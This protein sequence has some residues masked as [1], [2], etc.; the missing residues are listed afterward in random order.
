MESKLA[1][2]L[3]NRENIQMTIQNSTLQ[4]LDQIERLYT[5]ARDLQ[6]H[7]KMVV[8]PSFSKEMI[9]QEIE[10]KKQFKLMIDGQI[11]CVWAI[12]FSDPQIWKEKNTDAAIYIHRIATNRDFRGKNF[13]QK[14]VNWSQE[15]IRN[16]PINHI[17]LDT[18]GD[19]KGLIQHYTN[20]GFQF[21]GLF[22][23]HE[24]QGL[25]EHYHNATVSLFE[26]ALK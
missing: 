6:T 5:Q 15:Y 1:V 9:V 3:T 26:I 22:K 10:E 12:A 14:I 24:T 17:R 16:S 20:C 11:A 19:N 4:D 21:L 8:W 18:V 25:P 2:Y 23:L 7:L 13:V